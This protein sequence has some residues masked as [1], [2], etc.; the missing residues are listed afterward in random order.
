[1]EGT[2]LPSISFTGVWIDMHVQLHA[3]G[4]TDEAKADLARLA[5]I[6][7]EREAAQAKRKAEAEGMFF[8]FSR[9]Q[10]FNGP[11]PKQPRS[12]RSGRSNWQ[13][14]VLESCCYEATVVS[15][16]S[17]T[18][19]PRLR[20]YYYVRTRMLDSVCLHRIILRGMIPSHQRLLASRLP[21]ISCSHSTARILRSDEINRPRLEFKPL[22]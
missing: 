12:S 4:K 10:T 9:V 5:K 17:C 21:A 7:A 3:A 18:I 16:I 1:M 19:R 22:L 15:P 2:A 13:R 11:Q 20:M 8:L 6:R 14:S